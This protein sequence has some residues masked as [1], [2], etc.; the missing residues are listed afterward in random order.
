MKLK[1]PRAKWA[2][3]DEC[4]HEIASESGNLNWQSKQACTSTASAI[5]NGSRGSLQDTQARW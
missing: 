4:A 1:F 5:W 3:F 2:T